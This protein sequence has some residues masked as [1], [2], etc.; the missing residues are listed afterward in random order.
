[1]CR[2]SVHCSVVC[3]HICTLLLLLMSF[4]FVT[5]VAVVAPS[6]SIYWQ[7]THQLYDG[8]MSGIGTRVK[9]DSA[10]LIVYIYC[11]VVLVRQ[12][13]A[14]PKYLPSCAVLHNLQTLN[15]L[16]SI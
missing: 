10:I 11:V 13:D 1:M 7:K 2:A 4:R 9:L 8:M 5:L 15:M 16:T 3:F 6:G 14:K 12:Q